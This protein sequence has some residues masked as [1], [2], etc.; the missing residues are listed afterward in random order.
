MQLQ[1][2]HRNEWNSGTDTTMQ[3]KQWKRVDRCNSKN[4][5]NKHYVKVTHRNS[6]NAM[7]I[8]MHHLARTATIDG[9]GEPTNVQIQ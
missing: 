1:E 4:N 8:I 9:G 6:R 7:D 3:P 5:K 2:D